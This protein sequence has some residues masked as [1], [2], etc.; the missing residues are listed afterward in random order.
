MDS[1]PRRLR[2]LVTAPWLSR[3]ATKPLQ[4][5]V[6]G[7]FRARVRVAR[8]GTLRVDGY[9]TLGDLRT[10]SGYV[11]RS[12]QPS[13]DVGPGATLHI[14]GIVLAGD[15]TA[16]LA[17]SGVMKIGGGTT[18]DG[19]TRVICTTGMT[20]GRECSVAWGVTIMD[21]DFHSIDGRPDRAPVTIGDRVWIGV[22]ATIT[23]GVTIGDG[24]IIGAGAVVT[25][26]VPAKCIAA[27]VPAHVIR[28]GVEHG[29]SVGAYPESV[30]APSA[31][32]TSAGAQPTPSRASKK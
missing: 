4:L 25:K 21:A 8:G 2:R 10:D 32:S 12:L 13:V 9:L 16:L 15:G 23:K 1:L 5:R 6:R 28:E 22:G 18:F 24:A 20:I 17:E 3:R 26:D 11:S 29:A 27:G 19:D 14:H 30:S 7:N 31:V